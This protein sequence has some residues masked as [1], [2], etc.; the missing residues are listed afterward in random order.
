MKKHLA[1]FALSL[2]LGVATM[3]SPAPVL[4]EEHGGAFSQ[5]DKAAFLDARVAALKAGLKLTP[6]QEKYWPALESALRDYE[7]AKKEK[8]GEWRKAAHEEHQHKDFI[9]HLRKKAQ[10]LAAYAAETG[11]LAD[12]AKPLYDSLDDAQKHRLAILL[13]VAQHAPASAMAPKPADAH[14]A[15]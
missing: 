4:A 10:F 6:A 15:K 11:R 5:E 9:D 14:E 3:L 2:G 1:P 13:R 7:N 8:T 12:A